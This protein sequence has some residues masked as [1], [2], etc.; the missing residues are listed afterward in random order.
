MSKW[1]AVQMNAEDEDCGTGSYNLEEAIE[2]A[3]RYGEDAQI[4][5]IEEG[6]DPVCVE[7][8]KY[9]DFE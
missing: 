9:E 3:K 1:Y 7:I 8:I 5:V 2:M 6:K 4:A